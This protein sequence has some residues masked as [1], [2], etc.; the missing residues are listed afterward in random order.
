M[1]GT[2]GYG[3]WLTRSSGAVAPN[4]L[5]PLA[6]SLG[7]AAI[8]L[9]VVSAA[10]WTRR[11]LLAAA[12]IVGTGA[13]L[14]IPA[15]GTVLLASGHRG[16]ADTPFESNKTTALNEVLMGASSGKEFSSILPIFEK[17]QMGS[18]YVMAVYTSAVASVFTSASGKEFLPIGGFTG[19][20]PEPTI[21]QLETMIRTSKFHLVL[22]TGGMILA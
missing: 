7:V 18:P 20:I 21:S 15:S 14:V 17:L 12:I 13:V 11:W 6:A 22:L 19:S 16:Y 3:I 5:W 10:A 1:A 4:W 8:V 2:V 9:L